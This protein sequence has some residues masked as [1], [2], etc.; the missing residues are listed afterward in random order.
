[1]DPTKTRDA[2]LELDRITKFGVVRSALKGDE[3]FEAVV[4]SPLD[5]VGPSLVA[6]GVEDHGGVRWV[7]TKSDKLAKFSATD[8]ST[9]CARPIE[10]YERCWR[11]SSS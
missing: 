10:R 3:L 4:T 8:I 11:T 6:S 5:H 7:D 1:M 9:A 2:A